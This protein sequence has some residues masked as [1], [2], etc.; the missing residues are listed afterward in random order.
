MID[1]NILSKIKAGATV[2]VQEIIKEKDN[3]RFSNFEGVVIAR[4][5]GLEP[6][7][8]FTVRATVAGIGVEK[9]FPIYAPTISKV[10]VLSSPRKVH[11]SKLY[12][13]RNRSKK[14]VQQEISNASEK[15]TA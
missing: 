12:Y 14:E 3:Q 5:H 8:S 2:R 15:T 1:Q 10:D 6:G 13:L 11:R 4:K 7:A 9:V